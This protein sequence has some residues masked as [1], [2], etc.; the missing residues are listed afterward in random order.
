MALADNNHV[1]D[2]LP[3]FVLNTLAD[4]DVLVVR[5]H[6]R[7]CHACQAELALIQR[8]ADDLP[9]A[10]VQA[11][12]PAALKGKLLL[13]IQNK[14][15]K[16]VPGSVQQTALQKVGA[17]FRKNL[18]A[19]GIT[20][21]ILL[22]FGNLLLWRQLDLLNHQ[23]RSPL[24]VVT[25]TNTQ[26]SPGA[27]GTLV[28]GPN[29]NYAT[30]IVDHLGI[31]EPAKQYQVWLIKGTEHIS[32]AVFSVDP[33]GYALLQIQAPQPFQQYDTIGISIEPSGGSPAPTGSNVLHGGLIK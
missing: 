1:T 31:L 5:E 19:L 33:T 9:L 24:R 4:D 21:I 16:S 3:D 23:V 25:M 10:V 32:A 26:Y 14:Q 13:S 30:L 8:V 12:P 28:V 29:G 15:A 11:D 22:L 17:I 20:L 27:E 6:L 18:P 7:T 2:M